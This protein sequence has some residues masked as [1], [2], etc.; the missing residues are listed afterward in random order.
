MPLAT[1]RINRQPLVC[2][3][4]PLVS[5]DNRSY[6]PG[7]HSYQPATARMSLATTPLL[8]S[9]SQSFEEQATPTDS[10][11]AS[12][13][14]PNAKKDCRVNQFPLTYRTVLCLNHFTYYCTTHSA[15]FPAA[16]VTTM[17]RRSFPASYEGS[18]NENV[19]S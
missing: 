7:Y 8:Q 15:A 13:T 14:Q 2:P 16:S 18:S 1:T 6:V 4:L 12:P 17:V 10:Q 9:L 3:W 11:A 19:P 5:T